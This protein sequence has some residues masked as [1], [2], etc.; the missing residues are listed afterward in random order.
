MENRGGN[1]PWNDVSVSVMAPAQA[2]HG[3]VHR[4]W[5]P[6]FLTLLPWELEAAAPCVGVVLLVFTW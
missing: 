4:S 6:P 3:E 1:F 2:A 5:F